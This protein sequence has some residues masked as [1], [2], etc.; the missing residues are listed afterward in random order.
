MK[1]YLVFAS[2]I[3]PS[4]M[5][6][7]DI[8][9]QKFSILLLNSAQYLEKYCLAKSPKQNLTFFVLLKFRDGT[10]RRLR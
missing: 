8:L 3:S 4:K 5:I 6:L 9:H 2:L 10:D 7:F 1:H